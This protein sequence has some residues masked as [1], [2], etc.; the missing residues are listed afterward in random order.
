MPVD[1][2]GVDTLQQEAPQQ[3]SLGGLDAPPEPTANVNLGGRDNSTE[4]QVPQDLLGMFKTR[5]MY[6][7]QNVAVMHQIAAFTGREFTVADQIQADKMTDQ[8]LPLTD[9]QHAAEVFWQHSKTAYDPKTGFE[10]SGVLNKTEAVVGSG[11]LRGT[12]GVAQGLAYL[13]YLATRPNQK[14]TEGIASLI[15]AT[16]PTDVIK[17]AHGELQD[18]AERLKASYPSNPSYGYRDPDTGE[19][20]VEPTSWKT[21]GM[22]SEVVPT[23][24]AAVLSGGY[25]GAMVKGTTAA[26]TAEQVGAGAFAS[27]GAYG[28][29]NQVKQLALKNGDTEDSAENKANAAAIIGLPLDYWINSRMNPIIQRMGGK[30]LQKTFVGDMA[31]SAINNFIAGGSS[32]AVS[33]VLQHGLVIKS[34]YQFDPTTNA[35][36]VGYVSWRQSFLNT[37]EAGKDAATI[38]LPMGLA[39]HGIGKLNEPTVDK[40]QF[41]QQLIKDQLGMDLDV[42]GPKDFAKTLV[43]EFNVSEKNAMNL[44]GVMGAIL[45]EAGRQNNLT[46]PEA[47][48]TWFARKSER[49]DVI[50]QSLF[51]GSGEF[52]DTFEKVRTALTTT[53][54]E[55]LT[56]EMAQD[57]LVKAGVSLPEARMTG[58]QQLIDDSTESGKDISHHEALK[59]VENQF[60]KLTLPDEESQNENSLQRQKLF[61]EVE[62]AQKEGDS[63]QEQAQKAKP[64]EAES[65]KNQLQQFQQSVLEPLQQKYTQA[66]VA[67]PN[68][69]QTEHWFMNVPDEVGKEPVA[70]RVTVTPVDNNLVIGD[71]TDTSGTSGMPEWVKE[72]LISQGK[73]PDAVLN[74]VEVNRGKM[75]QLLQT[76]PVTKY[77]EQNNPKLADRAR[78]G[79]LTSDEI[80]QVV[81]Q[82]QRNDGLPGMARKVVSEAAKRGFQKIAWDAS[83]TD[84]TKE[85]SNV[86]QLTTAEVNGKT[87][88]AMEPQSAVEKTLLQRAPSNLDEAIEDTGRTKGIRAIRMT[89]GKFIS[90]D[91]D[92]H[93]QMLDQFP[94]K[95]DQVQDTGYITKIGG[96]YLYSTDSLG[97]E[98]LFEGFRGD[99]GKKVKVE[100][101]D[102]NKDDVTYLKPKPRRDDLLS[103]FLRNDARASFNLLNTGRAFIQGLTDPNFGSAVHEIAHFAR[104]MLLS[105]DDLKTVEDQMKVK[106]SEWEDSDEE[107]FVKWFEASLRR[108]HSPTPE[109]QTAFDSIGEYLKKAYPKLDAQQQTASMSPEFRNAIDRLFYAEREPIKAQADKT[110]V[111][112]GEVDDLVKENRKLKAFKQTPETEQDDVVTNTTR[113]VENE[114]AL[115]AKR[116]QYL[117]ALQEWDHLQDQQFNDGTISHQQQLKQTLETYTA[118]ESVMD[119]KRYG[120]WNNSMLQAVRARVESFAE[121]LGDTGAGRLMKVFGAKVIE[122]RKLYGAQMQPILQDALSGL[123]KK[124]VQFLASDPDQKGVSMLRRMMDEKDTWAGKE[125]VQDKFKTFVTAFDAIGENAQQQEIQMNM[126]RRMPSG[127]WVKNQ[128]Q[129]RRVVSRMLTPEGRAFFLNGGS[130]VNRYWALQQDKNPGSPDLVAKARQQFLDDAQNYDAGSPMSRTNGSLEFS[131]TLDHMDSIYYDATGKRIDLFV[132]DPRQLLLRQI[133]RDGNRLGTVKWFGQGVLQNFYQDSSTLRNVLSAFGVQTGFNKDQLVQRLTETGQ[134]GKGQDL[135]KMTVKDLTAIAEKI[136]SPTGMTPEDM[137]STLQTMAPSDLKDGGEDKIREIA[138][139]LRGVD[140][141]A[142]AVE[143]LAGIK[144]R[145]SQD[146]EDNV[147]SK[148]IDMHAKQGGRPQDMVQ[149]FRMVQDY[150]WDSI[151]DHRGWGALRLY[152]SVVGGLE[153]SLAPI[154]DLFRIPRSAAVVGIPD[155]TKALFKV[156]TD[157]Q[158]NWKSGLELGAYQETVRTWSSDTSSFLNQRYNQAR[159]LTQALFKPTMELV[160]N[161]TATAGRLKVDEIQNKY[162]D[163]DTAIGSSDLNFLRRMKVDEVEL[164]QIAEGKMDSG[165][166]A[167]IVQNVVSA[168]QPGQEGKLFRPIFDLDPKMRT[169]LPFQQYLYGQTRLVAGALKEVRQGWID[170]DRTVVGA[171]QNSRFRT[172]IAATLGLVATAVGSNAVMQM[173]LDKMKGTPA[174]PENDSWWHYVSGGLL[175]GTLLAETTLLTSPWQHSSRGSDIILSY[176]PLLHSMA[177]IVEFARSFVTP[178][179]RYG[180]FPADRRSFELVKSMTPALGA[181]MKQID[182]HAHP[183][184]AEYEEVRGSAMRWIDKQS[185]KPNTYSDDPINP[186]Y[187]PIWKAAQRNDFQTM[188]DDASVYYRAQLQQ[189]KDFDKIVQGLRTSLLAR[190]PVPLSDDDFMK[191]I[192]TVPKQDRSRYWQANVRYQSLVDIVAPGKD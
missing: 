129:L 23:V 165:T 116:G 89:D 184:L 151:E 157:Y 34:N 103:F 27:L 162:A 69:D 73:N 37:Y 49:E 181:A 83:D 192:A 26:L 25:Y 128:G 74:E 61:Q 93:Y 14:M 48:A 161:I 78:R 187:E 132:N 100:T 77:L 167:K 43:Q 143:V 113:L 160:N 66:G 166:Y 109:L 19:D 56:P 22:L 178:T 105:G 95:P 68:I 46:E 137:L 122:F 65:A 72:Q 31:S 148:L 136:D 149:A 171:M 144:E 79:D 164:K 191:F 189:G 88:V 41:M 97:R 94:L 150:P 85:M 52:N 96:K 50:G 120:E 176:S 90:S 183:D 28:R 152:Q 21:L 98:F 9:D 186:D 42:T 185:T 107:R 147:A 39:I 158:G 179:G 140:T 99:D 121:I 12:T 124:D 190:R 174:N 67:F 3:S 59:T 125:N 169:L 84:L 133:A 142:P 127:D 17:Q 44:S 87:M 81:N 40:Q 180:E 104:V 134:F 155:T 138:G 123:N 35:K 33:E 146:I 20:R 53:G 62:K 76:D 63:L 47:W 118:A 57:A 38:G 115:T 6:R 131:R 2:G 24:L 51:Q 110:A 177:S 188:K 119:P 154:K 126:Q 170:G 4:A 173:M 60:A 75:S 168:T 182:L 18:W 82:M 156:V 13:T 5:N 54:R 163:G 130:E 15:G 7:Q 106:G 32:Q 1:L 80:K 111:L 135:A 114:N 86:G 91:V 102:V 139:Q 153:T 16:A 141:K 159:E 36:N 145:L 101:V 55:S 64:E 175:E 58:L 172:A 30:E 71:R 112:K 29:Y 117:Q 70:S 11:L 45:S 10:Q 108:G 92:S 8:D